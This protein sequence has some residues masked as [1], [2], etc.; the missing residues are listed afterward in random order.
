VSFSAYSTTEE[1]QF[2]GL[3]FFQV[4]QRH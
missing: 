4:V 2:S 1:T 3:V